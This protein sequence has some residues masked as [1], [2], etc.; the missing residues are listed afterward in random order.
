MKLPFSRLPLLLTAL[1]LGGAAAAQ[2]TPAPSC[3]NPLDLSHLQPDPTTQKL[4][5]TQKRTILEASA[6]ALRNYY[7]DPRFGGLNLDKVTR[8]Y[9][10]RLSSLKNDAEFYE[11]M[12]DYADEL[13]DPH[14]YFYS[15]NQ[16]RA[17]ESA[18]EGSER[19]SGI[20]VTLGLREGNRTFVEQVHPGGPA[21]KAGVREGE[22]IVAIDGK[23]CPT[24]SR[25]RG[26]EGTRV[27][28]TLRAQNGHSRKVAVVRGAITYRL[29][30]VSQRLKAAG[31]IGY[32][33]IDTFERNDLSAEVT[34][35]LNALLEGGPLRGLVLDLRD[36]G[37]GFVYQGL[38][39]LGNFVQGEI[40]STRARG[41]KVL[42]LNVEPTALRKKLANVK[43]VVLVNE[44]TA[45]MA[46]ITA[47][48]LQYTRRAVVMGQT[49]ARAT[50]FTAPH[51]LPGGAQIF[52]AEQ[53]VYLPDGRRLGATG[54]VP[55]IKGPGDSPRESP[56]ADPLVRSAVTQLRK[57]K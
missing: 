22:E 50:E 44:N 35:R 40:G 14:V 37:G 13:N 17:A 29:E 27:V 23:P 12:R 2:A 45:S 42:E 32:L 43:L 52:V 46:E 36:N 34:R 19:Y 57:S 20:G 54:V 8:E 6:K 39:V 53:D 28:L 5:E 7:V 4:S 3:P 33:R 25:I 38:R 30:L 55:D 18:R 26:P 24:V 10:G 47:A 41:E 15:P 56:D 11:L 31:D 21:A 9:R 1:L 49:T 16:V 48:A 51:D